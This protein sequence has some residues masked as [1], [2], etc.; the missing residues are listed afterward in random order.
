MKK[1]KDTLTVKLRDLHTP[2]MRSFTSLAVVFYMN[3]YFKFKNLLEIGF[4]QGLTFGCLLESAEDGATL[5][6]ID[7]RFRMEIYDKFYKDSEY[8]KNKQ[9]NLV[10]MSDS[11]FE[12]IGVY[13][14]VN[15]DSGPDRKTP[16]MKIL[17]HVNEQS[18]IMFDN[19][20]FIQFKHQLDEF[21]SKSK[22][23]NFVPFLLDGGAM[24]FRHKNSDH[25]DFL[26]NFL[27]NIFWEWCSTDSI[28][29]LGHRVKQI[30][31]KDLKDSLNDM[32][33]VFREL[34]NHMDV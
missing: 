15:V 9:I 18:I 34:L 2:A 32:P 20:D 8:T 4:Y 31:P 26:D 14:F 23:H 10:Q 3:Q 5:T 21:I 24:Y 16:L 6:A 17:D 29:Y 11:E 28:D 22:S 7:T 19:Y 30:L 13:D 27:E 33:E 25:A 1:F 12:P